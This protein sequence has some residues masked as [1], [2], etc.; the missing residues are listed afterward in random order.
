MHPRPQ[1]PKAP[2]GPCIHVVAVMIIARD[3]VPA[4]GHEG[5]T[6]SIYGVQPDRA[7]PQRQRLRG[8]LPPQEHRHFPLDPLESPLGKTEE[9]ECSLDSGQIVN[10]F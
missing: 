5:L 7:H 6:G 2:S 8:V 4:L 9:G 3:F 1:Y 10:E